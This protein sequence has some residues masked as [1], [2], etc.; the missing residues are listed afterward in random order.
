[1][2]RQAEWSVVH[3]CSSTGARPIMRKLQKN[4]ALSSQFSEN[5]TQGLAILK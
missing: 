5:Q 4:R 3:A 2:K 1:V